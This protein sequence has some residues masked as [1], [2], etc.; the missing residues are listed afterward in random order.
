MPVITKRI[1]KTHSSAMRLPWRPLVVSVVSASSKGPRR[2]RASG[3]RRRHGRRSGC[4]SPS[5]GHLSRDSL[6]T[7]RLEKETCRVNGLLLLLLLLLLPLQ[8]RLRQW[9]HA[10]ND[11][12]IIGSYIARAKPFSVNAPHRIATIG[13]ARYGRSR[14]C[15]RG[16]HHVASTLRG[17]RIESERMMTHTRRWRGR[18]R[19]NGLHANRTVAREAT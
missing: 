13:A 1:S 14:R 15:D 8:L 5:L 9:G 17:A 4:S 18:G 19:R 16:R 10:R 6:L 11:M 7:E 12:R 3:V 2:F